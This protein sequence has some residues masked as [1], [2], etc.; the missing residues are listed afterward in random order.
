[1]LRTSMYDYDPTVK[2]F[3]ILLILLLKNKIKLYSIRSV[4][5]F[6]FQVLCTKRGKTLY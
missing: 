5:L 6:H 1:M 2:L 3:S 4:V